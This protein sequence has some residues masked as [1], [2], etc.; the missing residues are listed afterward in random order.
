[1]AEVFLYNISGDKLKKIR[2][3]MLRLGI[4]GRIVSRSEYGH[5]IGYLAGLEGFA[6]AEEYTGEGFASEMLVMAGLSSRQFSGLLDTLRASRAAVML[7]AVVNENNA[8]WSSVELH[9]ALRTEHDTM[10]EYLAVKK[11]KP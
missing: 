4:S 7:K 9:D 3:A 11:K 2:V 8:Q 1:M 10:Q 5:P 6:P